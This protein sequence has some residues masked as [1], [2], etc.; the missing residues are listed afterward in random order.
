M[1]KIIIHWHGDDIFPGSAKSALLNKIS[2]W[3]VRKDTIHLAPSAY[4]ARETEKRLNLQPNRVKVSPSG[5]VDTNVF[6][7]KEKCRRRPGLI[8]LGFASGLLKTKGIE[9]V[10]DLLKQKKDIETHLGYQVEFH[11]INYGAERD[12]YVPQLEA[13]PATVRH[14]PYPISRMVEF[15]NEFDILLFPSLRA[16]ESLGLVA[17]EAMACE[18][19]VI[20]TDAF[21]FKETIVEG[22]N[23]E[24]FDPETAGAFRAALLR[25]IQRLDSYMP[26]KFVVDR[27]S[28]A[29]VSADYAKLLG[30]QK[31]TTTA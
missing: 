19:P 15:Y 9:L 3:F 13:I 14:E 10:V 7:R 11:Y 4:F 23:G 18:S 8:R 2:Y 1:K 31:P 5:G 6:A 16:A 24:R 20:A 25:C 26:R 27:Y 30:D 29:A 12:S 28:K 22:V 17:L 21:A